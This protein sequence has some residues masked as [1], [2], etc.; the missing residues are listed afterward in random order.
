MKNK[1]II[2]PLFLVSYTLLSSCSF[3]FPEK[4]SAS[5]ASSSS[6]NQSESSSTTDVKTEK[7][8]SITS[9]PTIVEYY[10][11][12]YLNFTNLTVSLDTYENNKLVSSDEITDYTL[13]DVNGN[14][15]TSETQITQ[16]PADN[17][18]EIY[19]NYSG[20]TSTYFNIYIDDVSNYSQSLSI[21]SKPKTNYVID[22]TFDDTGLQVYLLTSYTRD[23][24]KKNFSESTSDYTLTIKNE[25]GNIKSATNYKFEESGDYSLIVTYSLDTSIT[26]TIPL[27][28]ASDDRQNN[29]VTLPDYDDDTI[30]FST[31]STKMEVT[32]TNTEKELD[33]DD[34]GYYSPS[35]V[36][37]EYNIKDYKKRNVYNWKFLPSTG[38]V[39]LLVIPVITPTDSAK[40][41][42]QNWNTI[43]KAFFGQSTELGFESLHSYYY[44]SSHKQLNLK[45][46][47]TGFFDPSTVDSRYSSLSGYNATSIQSLPALAASWAEST[48]NIDLT[49]YDYDK[50][51]YID[52]IWLVYLHDYDVTNTDTFWAYTSSTQAINS[53]ISTPTANNYAWASFKFIKGFASS[54]GDTTNA[55][56]D[57]HVLIH[58]TGHMLGIN[59]FYSYNTNSTYSP[60]GEVDMMCKNLGDMDPYVKLMLGW[61][62]PYIVYGSTSSIKIPSSLEKDALFVIPYDSKTYQKDSS[63]KVKF[64]AFDE[65]LILD[66]YSDKDLNA[67]DYRSYG[68][69]HVSG[70]GGRLYH[71]DARLGKYAN[72]SSNSVTL[73][74]DPDEPFTTD[75]SSTTLIQY[76]TNNEGGSRAE[77][78]YTGNAK[79]N[80]FDEIRW[81]S[82]DKRHLSTRNVA[83]TNSLFR[84]NDAF[85][86]TDYKSSFNQT[87][88]DDT[89]YYFNIQKTFSTSFTINSI[90]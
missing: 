9:L 87:S 74:S 42:T 16:V 53:N 63:G 12:D 66:Y 55:A 21:T 60:T 28:V 2:I 11:Y 5:S 1:K 8:L 29:V 81:I 65:Y 10:K 78:S 19:V 67:S 35:E 68:V 56:I 31:L 71:V 15:L 22:E 41:T 47:V 6:A 79:E 88:V 76:I 57:A 25:S 44:R 32:F 77:S 59:D 23:K 51:G 17:Y 46:G 7:K 26:S 45:G 54:Y 34:K 18:M 73:Y 30:S 80:A 58:E 69:S 38:D 75:T 82:R 24:K 83:N 13:T 50:D 33:A 4:I 90:A 70:N 39:P 62:T 48:Y 3:L 43:F 64:N 36:S 72:F 37:N 52:G 61:V 14:K 49:K 40:A 84:A 89:T 85:K 20:A 86:I 27:Y